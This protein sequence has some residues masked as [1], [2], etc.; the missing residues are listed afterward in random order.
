MSGII[1][2]LTQDYKQ[3]KRYYD[4]AFKKDKIL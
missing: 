1:I 4:D 2:S 3:K